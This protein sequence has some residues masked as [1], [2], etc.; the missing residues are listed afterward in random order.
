MSKIAAYEW[1]KKMD[2]ADSLPVTVGQEGADYST[3]ITASRSRQTRGDVELRR[4][5]MH[6]TR[7]LLAF[8]KKDQSAMQE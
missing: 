7:A 6:V 5:R 8:L 3:E 2:S 4:G 1:M